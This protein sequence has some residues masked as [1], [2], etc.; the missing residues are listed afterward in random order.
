MAISQNV[1]CKLPYK[2]L[3]NLLLEILHNVCK[4]LFFF[5]HETIY[6]FDSAHSY[7]GNECYIVKIS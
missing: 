1:V 7:S 2:E 4:V 6:L 3:V 5:K